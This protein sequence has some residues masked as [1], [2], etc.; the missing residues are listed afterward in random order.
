VRVE[1]YFLQ[2][3]RSWVRLHEK[4]G[5]RHEVPCHHSLD[6]YLDAWIAAAK[7]VEDKKGPLFR[8][9]KKGD[10]LTTNP[11]TRS[12]V[13]Y[14]IKRRAKGAAPALLHLL[15]YF[16][17]NRNH[18]LSAKRRYAGACTADSG[19]PVARTTKLYGGRKMRFRSMR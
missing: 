9:F 10:K 1:D 14:M 17:R 19:T 2:G 11:M 6:E 8:S 15:P 12:D 13:L 5:K 7:I 4:G 16:S 3:R 18:R